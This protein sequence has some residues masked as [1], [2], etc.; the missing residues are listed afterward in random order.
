MTDYRVNKNITKPNNTHAKDNQLQQF[1]RA[2][3]LGF[4][5]DVGAAFNQESLNPIPQNQ[6]ESS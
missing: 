1:P 3:M 4:D 2:M 5:I 6:A